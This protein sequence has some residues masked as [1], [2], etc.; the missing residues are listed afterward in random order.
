MDLGLPQAGPSLNWSTRPILY[1]RSPS[2]ANS[3]SSRSPRPA[4]NR[5]NIGRLIPWRKFGFRISF[6][7]SFPH[8][9]APARSN[10][11]LHTY[12]RCLVERI[13]NPNYLGYEIANIEQRV[14]QQP[15]P[16]IF[17]FFKTAQ[18]AFI[19]KRLLTKKGSA[20]KYW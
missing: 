10:F 18:R 2:R 7:P 6:L 9:N 19:I 17:A 14:I 3:F 4:K 15:L 8:W 11:L 1:S 13:A 20:L 16:S 5:I 12:T